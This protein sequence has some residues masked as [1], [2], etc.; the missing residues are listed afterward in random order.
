MIMTFSLKSQIA[1]VVLAGGQ[2]RRMNGRD[3][4]LVEING[5]AMCKI[6]IDLLAP[7]VGKV[8]VNANRNHNA[9]NV[10]GVP[11]IPD[12][13]TGFLGP[14]AGLASAMQHV[15]LEWVVTA[16][17]DG[18]FL[19]PD[20]VVRM[21]GVAV[22]GFDIVVASDG[23]RMQPTFLMAKTALLD[24]LIEFLDSGERK[25]DKWF[26]TH[27]FAL[28]DFSDSP[29]CFLNINTEEERKRVEIRKNRQ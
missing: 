24:S 21:S 20:Y 27:Q 12:F 19:N 7:Q 18:P 13:R 3:K 28:A 22:S 10:F 29:D 25:I 11:V 8:L 2:A 1:G 26:M 5:I 9:Y 16:P 15:E 4:G 17:C 23:K 6:V 14:L